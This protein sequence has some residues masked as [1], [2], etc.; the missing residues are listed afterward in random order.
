MRIVL[1]VPGRRCVHN[2]FFVPI[3]QRFKHVRMAKRKK[4]TV[5]PGKMSLP[6]T[7]ARETDVRKDIL[8]LVD[9]SFPDGL[10]EMPWRDDEEEYR[11]EKL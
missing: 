9:V 7:K 11:R 10:V 2:G 6:R 8:K 3:K 5:R 1:Q 4:A